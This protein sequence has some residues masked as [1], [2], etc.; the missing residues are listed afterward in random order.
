MKTPFGNDCEL[1]GQ[2]SWKKSIRY[3]FK[4]EYVSSGSFHLGKSQPLILEATLGTCVGVALYDRMNGVGGMIHLMLAEP[5]ISPG[6][7]E[8]ERY[9]T[10]G[11]PVFYNSLLKAGASHKNLQACIAGGALVGPLKEYDLDFD[12]GGRLTEKVSAFLDE[13]KI[14]I[15]QSETGGLFTC[16]LQLNMHTWETTI[17]PVGFDKKIDGEKTDKPTEDGIIRSLKKLQPIPQVALKLLRLINEDDYDTAT[18]T[19]EIRKD[20]VISGRTIKLCNSVYYRSN[21]KIESVDHAM[22]YLGQTLLIKFV[23]SASINNFFNQI[24]RGYSLCKGGLYHH[25]V[26]TAIISE[27]LAER[28]KKENT[29]LAY[30]A[31]LLHDIGKV[32]L[33]QFVQKAFPLFYR[34]V[35]Q[36]EKELLEVEET[37]FGTN[38]IRTGNILAK[39][40]SFP[41]SLTE[42]VTHHHTPEDAV[43]HKDLAHIV[44]LADLLMS[45]FHPGLE[46]DRLH[47]EALP[48]RL[49]VLDLSFESIPEILNELPIKVW[50]A[51][52]ERALI[53][54]KT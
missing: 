24:G 20:Q 3:H 6:K 12:I 49:A 10:T 18:L 52:P 50:E 45:R 28:T 21:N 7:F 26:G 30:T 47:T 40:W 37:L 5:P 53:S 22:V 19:T 29:A 51:S 31:G 16:V 44:F 33:D 11:L 34:Q 48:E 2:T 15:K 35:I 41:S 25:A 8:P 54:E 43:K 1:K 17:E 32:V 9:A 36:E 42:A 39:K 4:R 27:K 46:I 13:K 38:H 23:I 14:Y